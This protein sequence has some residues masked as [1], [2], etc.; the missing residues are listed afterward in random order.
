MTEIK[1]NEFGSLKFML[2]SL[3]D[4]ARVDR[5]KLFWSR[6]TNVISLACDFGTLEFLKDSPT[7]LRELKVYEKEKEGLDA[8]SMYEIEDEEEREQD[9]DSWEAHV[10]AL[11]ALLKNQSSLK[12]LQVDV[13]SSL[14]SEIEGF[15]GLQALCEKKGVALRWTGTWIPPVR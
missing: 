5:I 1:L 4:P 8:D 3:D 9:W 10:G 12:T 7:S 11:I 13:T 15:D 6:F 2:R 14:N